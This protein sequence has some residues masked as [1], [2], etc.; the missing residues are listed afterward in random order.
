MEKNKCGTWQR[1][2][3]EIAAVV[4]L[5][6]DDHAVNT[7]TPSTQGRAGQGMAVVRTREGSETVKERQ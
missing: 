2:R 5:C 1:L 7:T 4:D 3:V 6:C